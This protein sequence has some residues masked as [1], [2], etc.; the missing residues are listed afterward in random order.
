MP[1]TLKRYQLTDVPSVQAAL[2]LARAAWPDEPSATQLL[3][4]LIELG[5]S[6]LVDT[7]EARCCKVTALAGA[8][9]SRLG[10]DYLEELRQEW[11]HP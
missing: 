4:R 11:S 10:P 9:P 3:Y 7:A 2:D 8:F 1:T 5:A 6:D